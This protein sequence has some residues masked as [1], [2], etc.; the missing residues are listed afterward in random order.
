MRLS[1]VWKAPGPGLVHREPSAE[2]LCPSSA[3]A[4]QACGTNT[5]NG[6][7]TS[8]PL[9]CCPESSSRVTNH[10]QQ[11]EVSLPLKLSIQT[12]Y[13]NETM[14]RFS[15]STAHPHQRSLGCPATPE[16]EDVRMSASPIQDPSKVYSESMTRLIQRRPGVGALSGY[17]RVM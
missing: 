10:H 13:L 6:C 15:P 2:E 16:H 4:A 11:S 17:L 3:S 7:L 14:D 1:T 5:R 12:T 9:M 8:H